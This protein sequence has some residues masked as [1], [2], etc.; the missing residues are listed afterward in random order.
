MTSS[1]GWM[2]HIMECKMS[3]RGEYLG[4]VVADEQRFSKSEPRSDLFW[5]I[6]LSW[7]KADENG[8]ILDDCLKQRDGKRRPLNWQ[9]AGNSKIYPQHRRH[10]T[11]L[12]YTWLGWFL[13]RHSS[14]AGCS[15]W[16]GK[17][18]GT[19]FAAMSDGCLPSLYLCWSWAEEVLDGK[20]GTH[21]CPWLFNM[22]AQEAWGGHRIPV[23]EF[24][25]P[26]A[27]WALSFR[28]SEKS[29]MPNSRERDSRKWAQS[30]HGHGT[31]W[32]Y[33]KA[34]YRSEPSF[35]PRKYVWPQIRDHVNQEGW[36]NWPN[37]KPPAERW[38]I[39]ERRCRLIP[40]WWL[41]HGRGNDK[42]TK[43]SMNYYKNKMG[44]RTFSGG[45]NILSQSMRLKRM[46]LSAP[47]KRIKECIRHVPEE[48]GKGWLFTWFVSSMEYRPEKSLW[49]TNTLC[50]RKTEGKNRRHILEG[51]KNQPM[52][53]LEA[54][55][56]KSNLI[57]EI[58]SGLI[59]RWMIHQPV[60]NAL[61]MKIRQK[62]PTSIVCGCDWCKEIIDD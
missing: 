48:V 3:W 61:R 21:T 2:V 60:E 51:Q 26:Q 47:G 58:M 38:P 10:E 45:F 55:E 16:H 15:N 11:R 62:L 59:A 9:G 28:S 34:L 41:D 18:K 32:E 13:L 29:K 40:A 56:K 4:H 31:W 42:M 44:T 17:A 22:G 23:A 43:V 46:T 8:D 49:S 1:P 20:W 19:W 36:R 27:G 25:V 33:L 12:D 7:R 24:A 53:G 6:F 30:L 52:V 39:H 54:R 35:W 57:T 5:F 37:L 50:L 14:T